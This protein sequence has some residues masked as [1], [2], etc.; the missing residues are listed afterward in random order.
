MPNERRSPPF[1]ALRRLLLSPALAPPLAG[2]GALPSEL[3]AAVDAAAT[4]APGGSGTAHAQCSLSLHA[5]EEP[6]AS[7]SA[8]EALRLLL[9]AGAPVPTSFEEAGH[10]VHLNLRDEARRWRHVIGAVLLDKLGPRVRTVVTKRG[11]LKGPFRTFDAEARAIYG[12]SHALS[13]LSRVGAFGSSRP[14]PLSRVVPV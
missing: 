1:P 2:L 12:Q 4:S 13:Q 7:L 5:H 8:E 11:E 14:R 3:L 10:V 6:Y 9:P